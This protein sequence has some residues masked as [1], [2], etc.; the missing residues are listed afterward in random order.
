MNRNINDII[1]DI[2][3]MFRNITDGVKPILDNIRN[4]IKDNMWYFENKKEITRYTYMIQYGKTKRIR[5]K[6]KTK[7]KKLIGTDRA[8][9]II[10]DIRKGDN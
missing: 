8:L 10:D 4:T 7:L 3:I 6:Y 9:R 5:N 1:D 2:S